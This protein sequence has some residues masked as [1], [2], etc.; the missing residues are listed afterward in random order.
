MEQEQGARK[1]ARNGHAL[2]L[3]RAIHK[4]AD[5][6]KAYGLSRELSG[7][8][9]VTTADQIVESVGALAQAISGVGFHGIAV[10]VDVTGLDLQII[11]NWE[12]EYTKLYDEWREKHADGFEHDEVVR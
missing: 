4:I 12:R 11:D 6:C 1:S 10:W 9:P 7:P 3:G 2:K 8:R 5:A